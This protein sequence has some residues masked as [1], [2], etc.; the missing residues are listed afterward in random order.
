MLNRKMVHEGNG[1]MTVMVM[2]YC[3]PE[4]KEAAGKAADDLEI[5]LSEFFARGAALLLNRPELG[6]IP[7]KSMG[8]PR[9]P[10]KVR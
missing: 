7:R 1:R 8:R 4:L 2:V 5:P 9:G 3:S 10:V 6:R